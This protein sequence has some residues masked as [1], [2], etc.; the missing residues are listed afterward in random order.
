[1]KT[2]S[3]FLFLFIFIAA[4]IPADA[5]KIAFDP[6]DHTYIYDVMD[7]GSVKCIWSTTILPKA[8]NILYTISFRG[9]ETRDYQAMDSLGNELDVNV[10]EENGQRAVSLLLLNSEI[11]RPYQFNLSFIWNGL[12]TRKESKHT[13]YTSVNI[14]EPQSTKIVVIPP[15]GAKIGTSVVNR[16]NLSEPFEREVISGRDALV[17][18]TPNSGNQTEIPF[19][20]NFNYYDIQ[21]SFKDNLPKIVCGA[22]IAVIVAL[23]LGYRKRLPGILSKTKE[24]LR[25]GMR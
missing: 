1:M 15:K 5:Q 7:D 8:P 11:G 24:L 12:L 2:L 23:L 16:Y 14:G 20:A 6:I 10:D 22:L 21:L 19:R 4:I 18:S 13:I 25:D 17:W 9:G 3:I